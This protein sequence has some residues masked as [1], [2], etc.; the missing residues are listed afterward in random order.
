MIIPPAFCHFSP[1]NS[2]SSS[3][4]AYIWTVEDIPTDLSEKTIFI[5]GATSGIGFEAARVFASRKC[6]LILA[7][8]NA[9]RMDAVA[10]IF[11]E[12]GS[13]KVYKL[14]CDTSDLE[15]V[16]ACATS[17]LALPS[18]IDVLLLNAGT[19]DGSAEVVMTANHLGHFLLTGLMF[20][21]L[22][23]DARIISV[24]SLSHEIPWDNLSA[25]KSDTNSYGYSKLANLLF[26]EHL[27]HLLVLKNSSVMVVGGHPGFSKSDIFSKTESGGIMARISSFAMSIFAQP[28][29][30][31]AWP[32]LMAAA[33][34]GITRDSY[35]AP[36]KDS[37]LL[38]EFSGSPMRNG[39]KG[40]AAMDKEAA[41]RC[42]KESERIT[43]FEFKI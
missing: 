38:R 41:E 21:H 42:W 2:P 13:S 9:D 40:K 27:N 15:S 37:W 35:Y 36:S 31:G 14:V 12:E 19:L 29:S 34:P 18:T 3:S 17:A 23:G 43:K 8:R 30:D 10:A 5:T 39:K 33:D 32:L 26:V 24:S 6:N 20:P 22:A 11:K 4:M 28:T 25:D 7:C 16:R 1:I